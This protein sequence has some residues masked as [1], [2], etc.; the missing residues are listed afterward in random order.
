MKSIGIPFVDKGKLQAFFKEPLL[1]KLE[2]YSILQKP[3]KN[4]D[5]TANRALSFKGHLLQ[6]LKQSHI[7]FVTLRHWK[8]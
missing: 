4:N 8:Y 7:F 5:G 2:N 3:A 6:P 1:K